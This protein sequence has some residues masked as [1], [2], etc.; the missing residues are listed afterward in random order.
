M[1]NFWQDYRDTWLLHGDY[2]SIKYI[3]YISNSTTFL[4]TW[5]LY[6]MKN[7]KNAKYHDIYANF[8]FQIYCT[9]FLFTHTLSL[10]HSTRSLTYALISWKNLYLLAT[11]PCVSLR[12]I[13]EP[14]HD[15]SLSSMLSCSLVCA[16]CTSCMLSNL[17]IVAKKQKTL[18]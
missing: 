14:A 13:V 4:Q 6:P 7:T 11:S 3:Q 15:L 9:Y 2:I 10:R 8:Y 5:K 1:R 18:C 16:L 17:Q 12:S